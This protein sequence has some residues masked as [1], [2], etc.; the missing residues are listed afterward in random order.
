MSILIGADIVPTMS[1]KAYFD[2]GNMQDVVGDE[3]LNVLSNSVYRIFNLE[4]P[5]VNVDSPIQK[6]GPNLRADVLTVKGLKSIGVDLL[7]L[8]NNH[9]MDHGNAGLASTI[10]VLEKE[11]I[12]FLGAGENSKIAAMPFVFSANNKKIGVCACAEHEFSIAEENKPGANPFDPLESFDHV[13]NLKNGC[14]YVIVLYHGGKEHYRYPSPMLQRI[15]RKFVDKGADLVICQHSHCIG[16]EEKY[17]DGTIVYGQGNFI[18]NTCDESTEQ[19]S[20][21]VRIDDNFNVDY[22]P[23][24]K[25]GCGARLAKDDIAKKI[26]SEF[27]QRSEQIKNVEFVKDEYSKFAKNMVNGYL[28]TCSGYGHNFFLKIINKLCQHKLIK[29]LVHRFR[30]S[31]LIAIRN[32]IECEA[33]RELFVR[34]LKELM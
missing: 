12:S 29:F 23:L 7:T 28:L 2:S 13:V 14:D 15:C 30:D 8:A 20:L 11:S 19:T 18:F 33:H 25:Y 21:L 10:S 1:N 22:I 26:L 31:E 6:C 4:C 3:L 27:Y 9:I 24:E 5:L 32:Y 17:L 16:C 34:G